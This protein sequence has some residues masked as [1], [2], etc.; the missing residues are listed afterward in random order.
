[1]FLIGPK[2]QFSHTKEY[3]TGLK[4][5][6][7]DTGQVDNICQSTPRDDIL[8]ECFTSSTGVITRQWFINGELNVE[9]G[10]S[11]ASK[12]GGNF[13]CVLTNECGNFNIFTLCFPDG[14]HICNGTMLHRF[15]EMPIINSMVTTPGV[16]PI[17]TLSPVCLNVTGTVVQPAMLSCS[18]QNPERSC[19]I[20]NPER[21]KTYNLTW[22]EN[23]RSLA[24]YFNKTE[25]S[26]NSSGLYE[27]VTRNDCGGDSKET[28][29]ESEDNYIGDVFQTPWRGLPESECLLFL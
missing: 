15:S 20:Q 29:I 5:T 1:M 22:T 9:T 18:V 13:S 16:I 10:C 4:P 14:K 28:E 19:S 2:P 23:G 17:G 24:K 7:L 6:G 21:S 27:C 8:I 26:V 12:Q 11:I 3:N 25:I